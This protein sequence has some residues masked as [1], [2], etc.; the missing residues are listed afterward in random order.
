MIRYLVTRDRAYVMEDFLDNW[1][2]EIGLRE[3]IRVHTYEDPGLLP[4]DSGIWI[5]SDL[6]RLSDRQLD[7]AEDLARQIGYRYVLNRPAHYVRRFPL[8]RRLAR[9]GSNDFRVWCLGE[10]LRGKIRFP[11]FI[12]EENDHTG[13][14]TPLINDQRGIDI[15]VA[16]LLLRGFRLS[17]LMLIEFCETASDEGLYRKYAAFRVGDQIIPRHLI[18][19][20]NWVLK[21]P[22]LVTD[23]LI[24]EE[25]EYPRHNPHEARLREIF[26]LSGIDYGRIDYSLSDGCIQTWE[27]N[28]N[29]IIVTAPSGYSPKKLANQALF[30]GRIAAAFNEVESVPGG[31]VPAG[32]WGA[33]S[34]SQMAL[35]FDTRRHAFK[36]LL[37]L[38]GNYPTAFRPLGRALRLLVGL[39]SCQSLVQR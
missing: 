39:V 28:T 38:C 13:N 35:G 26:E 2:A 1:G 24:R 4:G 7:V 23:E 12:R 36:R 32:A 19:S 25:A 11:V 14:L 10:A 6:E 3:N 21:K 31:A 8:L 16:R 5:F 37:R 15:A 22:D 20:R 9:E 17:H 33:P 30:A 34:Q 27:I 29:P 18:F